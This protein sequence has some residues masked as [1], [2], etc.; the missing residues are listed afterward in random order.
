MVL[1]KDIH[2]VMKDLWAI[3]AEGVLVTPL[4]TNLLLVLDLM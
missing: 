3:G 2:R 4:P 1:R